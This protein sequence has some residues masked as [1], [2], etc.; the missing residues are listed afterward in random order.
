M[1]LLD[2]SRTREELARELAERKGMSLEAASVQTSKAIE[3]MTILGL[4]IG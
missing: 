3:T 1:A 4:M 2:G